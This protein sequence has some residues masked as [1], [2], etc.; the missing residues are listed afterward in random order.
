MIWIRAGCSILSSAGHEGIEKQAQRN[1]KLLRKTQHPGS[2]RRTQGLLAL[3]LFVATLLTALLHW[4][5]ALDQFLRFRSDSLGYYQYL[6]GVFITHDLY[7]L[8]WSQRLENGHTLNLFC[9]GV[10]I[11]QLPFFCLGHLAATLLGNDVDGYSAPYA[12]AQFVGASFYLSVA[13]LL[14]HGVLRR[15]FDGSIPWVA[16]LLIVGCSTL[17]YYTSYEAGMSHGYSFFLV[18]ALLYLTC[19]VVD[20]ARPWHLLL[21]FPVLGSIVLTRPLN[22]V[23]VLVPLLWG[24]SNISGFRERLGVLWKWPWATLVG[25]GVAIAMTLPQLAYWHAITGRWVLF[26]YGVKEEGFDFSAPHLF[27]VLISHQ[28]GWFIYSP[29]MGVVMLALLWTAWRGDAGARATLLVWAI[30]WYIYGSWW[31]WWLGGAYG[32]RGFIEYSALLVVPL[33]H[34]LGWIRGRGAV[35][36]TGFAVV[37]VVFAFMNIRMSYIY[38]APWDGPEWTWRSYFD[39]V[40]EAFF[41]FGP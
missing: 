24:T 28:N 16:V 22:G 27:D 2:D 38:H 32:Y 30:A 39:K 33:A 25:C 31:A 3:F 37:C 9:I 7:E 26:T 13:G 10:S 36:R 40:Q 6:P 14:L 41:I 23:L 18:S 19:S 29:F 17:Y 20:D 5:G 21:L 34:L 8:P 35:L 4:G 12:V 11:L 1:G 15:S